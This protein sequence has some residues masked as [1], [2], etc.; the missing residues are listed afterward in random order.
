MSAVYA[1]LTAKI[2]AKEK[3]KAEAPETQNIP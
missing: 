1:S 2:T 3:A